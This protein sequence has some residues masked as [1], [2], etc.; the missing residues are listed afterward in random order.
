[1]LHKRWLYVYNPELWCTEPQAAG[2]G[3]GDSDSTKALRNVPEHDA[4]KRV[5]NP[6]S[7]S[8]RSAL[9]AAR[10]E[11]RKRL[12]SIEGASEKSTSDPL[13]DVAQPVE[14]PVAAKPMPTMIS[15]SASGSANPAS[16][17]KPPAE[18]VPALQDVVS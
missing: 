10:A 1:M 3:N 9:Q 5:Q 12:S 14:P 4:A 8:V 15:I 16:K 7:D 2:P 6:L 17:A 13:P 18:E 11:A